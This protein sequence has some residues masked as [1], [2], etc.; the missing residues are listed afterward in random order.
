MHV[1]SLTESTATQIYLMIYEAHHVND[2]HYLNIETPSLSR[3]APTKIHD[4]RT[5][6]VN[7]YIQKYYF[8]VTE[9]STWSS[10]EVFPR[11]L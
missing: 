8:L 1:T 3:Q 11:V 10:V 5:A 9:G 6:R 4:L 2:K 7:M